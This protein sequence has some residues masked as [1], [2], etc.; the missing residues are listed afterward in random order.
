M[1]WP[2]GQWFQD[3]GPALV[4]GGNP[5][6]KAKTIGRNGAVTD[7]GGSNLLSGYSI[8]KTDSLD[9]AVKLAKGCPVIQGGGSIEVAETFAAM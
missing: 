7:G 1:G 9:A 8:V 6:A 3:L 5:A 2:P 4:D